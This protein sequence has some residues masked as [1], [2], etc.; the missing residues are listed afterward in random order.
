MF[1]KNV[2]NF[3]FSLEANIAHFGLKLTFSGGPSKNEKKM[4]MK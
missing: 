2:K 4:I 1:F 3:I